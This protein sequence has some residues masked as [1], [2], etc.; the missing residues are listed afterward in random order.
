LGE[1]AMPTSPYAHLH[2][3]AEFL[4]QMRPSSILDIGLG[5]GQLGFIA[6]DLLD[7]RLGGRHGR[8]DWRLQL[9]GIEILEDLI[10]D[11]QRA[12]YNQIHIGDAYEAIDA[13]GSYDMIVL[14]D[15]LKH[16]DKDRGWLF[17]DRCFR[18]AKKSVCLLVTLGEG[19]RDTAFGPDPHGQQHS[20]WSQDEFESFSSDRKICDCQAGPYGA[21]LIEKQN[22][23]DHRVERL[24]VEP[25]FKGRPSDL[26]GIRARYQLCKEKIG[27]IDLSPKACFAAS[28]EYRVYFLDDRFKEHY[29]LLAHLSCLYNDA[30]LFDIGTSRGYSALAF[31]Y[32]PRNRVVS[33]D[34]E[35]L[36]DLNNPERLNQIDFRIGNALE[37]HRLVSAPLILLDTDHDGRFESQVIN[38]LV[39][40]RFRGLLILDDIHLNVSMT[41]LWDNITLPKE[42]VTDLG[43][44]SG[45][46]LVDFSTSHP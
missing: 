12:I 36:K 41:E 14:G 32:H 19:S 9:D 46:G 16:F 1:S 31:S 26:H 33:Y 24:K 34:I 22:Y 45:T 4:D 18:H 13:L 11:H 44:W 38:F 40:N 27:R 30:N 28:D 8:D 17:L 3:F 42:D 39:E 6:R 25:Y 23:I 21:F 37:D 29:R 2:S 20:V 43:H 35:D 7:V 5:N 10:Q 15:I